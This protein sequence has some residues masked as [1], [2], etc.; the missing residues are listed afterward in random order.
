MI[1]KWVTSIESLR[2]TALS[3]FDVKDAP[4]TGRRVAENV[5]KITRIIETDRHVNNPSIAQ[6]LKI[7][8]KTVLSHL[9]KVGFKKKLHVWVPHQSTPKHD[10][11]N[12]NLRI[13]GQTE[14]NLPISLTDG[15]WG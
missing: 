9:R 1:E 3:I 8:H 5:D 13:L 15:D 12:F 7:A 14:R 11:S 10:G 4:R 2:S 6:E